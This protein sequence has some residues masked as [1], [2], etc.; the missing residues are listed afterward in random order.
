MPKLHRPG[1]PPRGESCEVHL[2]RSGLAVTGEDDLRLSLPY[3]Q[4]NGRLAGYEDAYVVLSIGTGEG[5]IEVWVTRDFMAELA[6]H[7]ASFSPAFRRQYQALVSSQR[8]GQTIRVLSPVVALVVL[9][10][11]TWFVM[12]GR[13]AATIVE[14]I[15][16][17]IEEAIGEASE[18][19][20]TSD[21]VVCEDPALVDAT[22]QILAALVQ[23]RPNT[24]YNF[25]ITLLQ[26]DAV[27]AYALPGGRLFVLSGLLEATAN[28]SE[29]AAVLGHEMQH[30][31]GR[32]G[33]RGMVHRAGI[34]V[35]L[36]MMLGDSTEL[37]ALL[38]SVAGELGAVE[39]SRD[40][41]REA[42]TVGLDL[43]AA[44]GFDPRAPATFWGRITEEKSK[45]EQELESL[46]SIVSTHPPSAERNTRLMDLASNR[47]TPSPV[48]LEH[49]DWEALKGRCSV[50]N[51]IDVEQ[52]RDTAV[53]AE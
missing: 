14:G 4:M 1:G 53:I 31:L 8:K 26:S 41:E 24:G 22:E 52:Q 7:Q 3:E 34:G 32:H 36:G 37:I 10:F 15:P 25:S 42:D 28:P 6:S 30:V 38:G 43:V 2:T 29:V 27:N 48:A 47:P 39:F 35:A 13:L 16:V 44:A 20:V 17:A 18:E 9:A 5:P 23:A 40:H 12:S 21:H 46:L 19:D 50:G 11:M 49:L 51:D 33:L 45:G